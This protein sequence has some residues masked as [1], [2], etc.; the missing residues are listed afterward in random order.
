MSDKPSTCDPNVFSPE[1]V[2]YRKLSSSLQGRWSVSHL[3]M[4]HNWG[5]SILVLLIYRAHECCGR[6]QDLVNKNEDGF[7]RSELNSLSDNIDE[8][9]NRQVLYQVG[10]TNQ[11]DDKKEAQKEM[12]MSFASQDAMRKWLLTDGTKYFFLSMVGISVRSAFSQI[13][14]GVNKRQNRDQG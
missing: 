4:D 10:I 14:Y 7:L 8:L 13:T 2:T 11:S 3:R 12:R 9:P 1:Y 6:R 5:V